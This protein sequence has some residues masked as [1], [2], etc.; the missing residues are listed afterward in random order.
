[1]KILYIGNKLVKHGAT[2]TTIDTLGL[3]LEQCGYT[4]F[5]ASTVKNKV[6]R[7]LDMIVKFFYHLPKLDCVLIDTYSTSNFYYALIISQLCRVFNK[8]YLAL[9]HG[10]NLPIRLQNNPKLSR[11]I[12]ENSYRNVAPSN[13]LFNIFLEHFPQNTIY[14]PNTID[15][16]NYPFSKKKFDVPRL[17]WVRS[18]SKIYNPEMAIHVF[19]SI[20]KE[21][22]EATLCLVGPDKDGSLDVCKKLANVKNL[23]VLFTGKLSQNEWIEL[24]KEYNIFINTTH[25]DNL[26]VSVIEAMALG[27]PVISTNVGGIPYLIDNEIDGFLVQDNAVSEMIAAIKKILFDINCT[28]NCIVNAKAKTKLFDWETVKNQWI[29]VLNN[30]K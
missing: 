27:L 10:G 4:L 8:K 12:F 25:F 23:D 1:M 2:P 17:F 5:Y 13:Y 3:R 20:K 15:T 6:F 29:F 24:S 16:E 18:F 14:I 19:E 30:L 26:P 11:L 22:P 21:F 9:L 28:E 7:L